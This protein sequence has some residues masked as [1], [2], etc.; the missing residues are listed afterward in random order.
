MA[1]AQALISDPTLILAVKPMCNLDSENTIALMEL[2][3]ELNTYE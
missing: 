3:K 1:I 2:V